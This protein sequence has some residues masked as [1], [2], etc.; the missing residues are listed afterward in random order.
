MSQAD[1]GALR[2]LLT[3]S[4]AVVV[5]IVAVGWTA[6]WLVAREN[7]RRAVERVEL[8]ADRVV[9]AE[10]VER[11][12]SA[13]SAG[14]GEWL[15]LLQEQCE[16]LDLSGGALACVVGVGGELLA[17]PELRL[18]PGLVGARVRA[19]GAGEGGEDGAW[20]AGLAEA[21]GFG[22][23]EGGAEGTL[24]VAVLPVIG[25]ARVVARGVPGQAAVVLIHRRAAVGSGVAWYSAG[26]VG[27]VAI[28]GGAVAAS[29]VWGLWW[30]TRRYRR[31]VE[32][33]KRRLEGEVRE[34]VKE[35]TANRDALIFG[36]AKLSDYR[37][38][39]TGLHLERIG[40]YAELLVRRLTE[41][42]PSRFGGLGEEWVSCLRLAS[43]LHDIGKVGIPD[44]IL[45]KPGRLTER[46][47][48]IMQHHPEIGGDTLLAIR[49]R[50][51]RSD[52][53]IDMAIE[54]TLQ[55][56]ER[57][58][59]KG[60]PFG[61]AGEQISL[62][63]RIV[64]LADFYDAITSERPYKS[65]YSHSRAVQMVAEERGRQFDPAVVDAFM[66][67]EGLFDSA[68]GRLRVSGEESEPSLARLTRRMAEDQRRAA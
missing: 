9:L 52:P 59:G 20:L 6:T 30:L 24:G 40:V 49:R 61:L 28:G 18:N 67:C 15:E 14:G 25:E 1:P 26:V 45:L 21:E 3:L 27:A 4:V 41:R 56:H 60:Y 29:S 7:V 53:F 55:H 64:A 5:A 46:E 34:Q 35:S 31:A 44:A 11:S 63:A 65:A 54:I 47:R 22:G 36:L 17:H 19:W 51:G 68:R 48:A 66:E 12:S 13:G 58:D 50:L 42:N 32:E 57:W 39:D 33:A 23:G 2:G 8:A 37:D 62:A 16:R 38:N 43:S 10:L